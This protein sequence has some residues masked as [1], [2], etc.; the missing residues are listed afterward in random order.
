MMRATSTP[1]LSR[2]CA[3]AKLRLAFLALVQCVDPPDQHA[4]WLTDHARSR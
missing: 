1:L 4:Q 2:G 3:V